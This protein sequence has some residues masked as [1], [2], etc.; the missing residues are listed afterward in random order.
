MWPEFGDLLVMLRKK[1]HG[2][3]VWMGIV[4]KNDF[5]KYHFTV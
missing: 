1:I 2:I 3:N 4:F 5:Q